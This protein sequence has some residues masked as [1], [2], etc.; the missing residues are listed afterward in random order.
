MENKKHIHIYRHMFTNIFLHVLV[1]F[2]TY[3]GIEY[4]G[5]KGGVRGT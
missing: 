3:H 2:T 5:E 4:L 1:C